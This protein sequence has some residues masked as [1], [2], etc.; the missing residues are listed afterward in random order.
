MN[1]TPDGLGRF[2]YIGEDEDRF[3]VEIVPYEKLWADARQRNAIFFEKLGI[4]N[5]DVAASP[6]SEAAEILGDPEP[7]EG[8]ESVPEELVDS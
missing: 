6:D 2:G 5:H 7:G 8:D 3:F 1:S 4:T